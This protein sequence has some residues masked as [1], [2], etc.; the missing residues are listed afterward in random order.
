MTALTWCDKGHQYSAADYYVDWPE[1]LP[2]CPV[3][4]KE[5]AYSNT[6]NY[7]AIELLAGLASAIDNIDD[8]NQDRAGFVQEANKVIE[9]LDLGCFYEMEL[10]GKV[11]LIDDRGTGLRFTKG[12]KGE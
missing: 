10:D 1:G 7:R 6:L 9:T 12:K 2:K 4:R 5:W 11:Y 3:C 8:A